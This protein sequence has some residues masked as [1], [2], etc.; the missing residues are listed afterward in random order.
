MK[1]D[2][3]KAKRLI[4]QKSSMDKNEYTEKLEGFVLKVVT[5]VMAVTYNR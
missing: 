4:E 2:I 5:E 3:E 1:I